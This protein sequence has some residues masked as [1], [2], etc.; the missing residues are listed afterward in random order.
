MRAAVL[1]GREDVRVE[2]VPVPRPGAGEVLLRNRVALTCGTDVKVFRRGYH[3]RMLTPPALF[4]HEL[5]GVVEEVGP[6][7][8]GPA[9]G[10]PV[11]VANSAPCGA[12]EYCL[13]L[14]PSLCDDLLFWNGAYAEFAS[15]PARIVEKNLLA[16]PP[17]LSFRR[18]AMVEPLACVVRGVEA[19]ALRAGDT[20]AVIGVGPIGLMF[21]V[22]L[23]ERGVRVVAAGRSPRRLQRALEM[24]ALAAVSAGDDADLAAELRRHSPDGR[25]AHAV[26]EAAGGAA[27]SEAA[28]RAVRKGG[29]VNLFG[30]CPADTRLSVDAA[31]L[32]YEEVTVLAT[33]HHTPASV[34]EA[35]CLIVEGR[36]DP[37]QFISGEEPLERLPG[38][39]R[40]M[41]QGAEGLK[42][43]IL[44]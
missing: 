9:P 13:A 20:A 23:R 34:R 24:G 43:A 40:R 3:A 14:R 44:T 42:T 5:A 7:V 2:W 30:G 37:E 31:R 11:V 33:F 28:V 21:V 25:G 1:H 19:C 36:I 18:A 38:V 27:T 6:G 39:L 15:I 22:L 35:L 16:L 4:G 10:T 8:A 17:G 12:C 26:V 29:T 32:H 41:A